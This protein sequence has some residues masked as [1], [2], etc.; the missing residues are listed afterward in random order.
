MEPAQ[1]IAI[2][3]QEG[4]LARLRSS[5]CKKAMCHKTQLVIKSSLLVCWQ[6]ASR[7]LL[8]RT[9]VFAWYEESMAEEV[10]DAGAWIDSPRALVMPFVVL[11]T[12]KQETLTAAVE[13][14]R[15][16]RVDD[17]IA[18][19]ARLLKSMEQYHDIN[20]KM[21]VGQ[22]PGQLKTA[23]KIYS[24]LNQNCDPQLGFGC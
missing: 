14:M 11:A 17:L 15:R 13:N 7:S 10:N 22:I 24:H 2:S 18:H 5:T 19:L 4:F 23:F 20:H 1:V 21:M 16:G 8:R 9:L 3:L 12:V 6:L